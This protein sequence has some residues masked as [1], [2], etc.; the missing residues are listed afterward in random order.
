MELPKKVH[1]VL[2]SLSKRICTQGRKGDKPTN[3]ILSYI[4]IFVLFIFSYKTKFHLNKRV[5]SNINF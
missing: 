1:K 3:F 2:Y 5:F 4:F